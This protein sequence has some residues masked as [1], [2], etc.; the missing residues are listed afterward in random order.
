[1]S[2]SVIFKFGAV[3][4]TALWASLPFVQADDPTWLQELTWQL[5]SELQCEPQFYVNV[6]EGMIGENVYYEARVMCVDGRS[7][8]ANRINPDLHFTIKP[9]EVEVC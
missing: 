5:Q 2:K 8:D 3:F 7:F 4:L 6:Q 9:C 1:M